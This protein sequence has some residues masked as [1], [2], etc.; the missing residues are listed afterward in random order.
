[1][2]IE[3]NKLNWIYK[4]LFTIRYFEERIKKIA[5]EKSVPGY[6]HTCIGSEA[7]CVGAMSALGDDDWVSCT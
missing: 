6:L 4:K 5:K 7:I 3:H 2:H 1:M